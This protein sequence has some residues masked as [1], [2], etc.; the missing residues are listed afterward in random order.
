MKPVWTVLIFYAFVELILIYTY[1][2]SY[3]RHK[4]EDLF[5]E[6]NAHWTSD[7]M[8]VCTAYMC[9]RNLVYVFIWPTSRVNVGVSLYGTLCVTVCVHA[10]VRLFVCV[11]MLIIMFCWQPPEYWLFWGLHWQPVVHQCSRFVWNLS[12]ICSLCCCNGITAEVF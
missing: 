12:A 5:E 6:E 3:I 8:Y 10:R 11:S 2:F 4:W 7:E 9:N 1:Q